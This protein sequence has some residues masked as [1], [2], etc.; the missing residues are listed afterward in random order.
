MPLRALQDRLDETPLQEESADFARALVARHRGQPGRA[1]RHHPADGAQL[2][3]GSDEPHRRLHP[4][5]RHL[6]D[7]HGRQGCRSKVAIN[8][9]VELAKLFGSDSSGRFVNGVLGSVAKQPGP[10]RDP[11]DPA[12]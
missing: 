3:P 11:E 8:E 4:A 6:R 9:A 2:A 10:A 7:D 1:G 5:A 12:A